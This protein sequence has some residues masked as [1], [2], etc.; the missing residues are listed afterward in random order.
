MQVTSSNV[1]HT[2][3][4]KNLINC[5]TNMFNS[6][7][8]VPASKNI[9]AVLT[10]TEQRE[11]SKKFLME[12]EGQVGQTSSKM[13]DESNLTKEVFITELNKYLNICVFISYFNKKPKTKALP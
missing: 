5:T 4:L 13:Y 7:D 6:N 8:L 3:D 9:E 11:L 1:K 2:Q 10:T 12:Q